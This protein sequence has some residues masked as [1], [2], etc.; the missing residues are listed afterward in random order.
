[1]YWDV[2]GSFV[3]IATLTAAPPVYAL[4]L[5]FKDSFI[6]CKYT[7]AVFRHFLFSLWPCLLRPKDLF[8]YYM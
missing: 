2:A 5:F 1:M 4:L 3:T 6:I 8:I 7:V